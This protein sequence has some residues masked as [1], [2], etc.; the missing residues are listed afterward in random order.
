MIPGG[1]GDCEVKVK[2]ESSGTI[3]AD[4]ILV[5]SRSPDVVIDEVVGWW[6]GDL[7]PGSYDYVDVDFHV[8][9]GAS[10]G[11][12]VFDVSVTCSGEWQR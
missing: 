6:G 12:F 2:N 7:S 1:K 11:V 5:T 9:E 8:A 4:E 10:P 3:H